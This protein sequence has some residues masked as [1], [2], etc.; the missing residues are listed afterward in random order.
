MKYNVKTVRHELDAYGFY[1]SLL[2]HK[3]FFLR[4]KI[5]VYSV[6]QLPQ[7]LSVN[8]GLL[9]GHLTLSCHCHMS[10]GLL[11]LLRPQLHRPRDPLATSD[12]QGKMLL[13]YRWEKLVSKSLLHQKPP[14]NCFGHRLL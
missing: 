6:N 13:G 7:G 5:T 12:H 11:L 1:S 3:P 4:E 9:E 8:I 14:C 2:T 10:A